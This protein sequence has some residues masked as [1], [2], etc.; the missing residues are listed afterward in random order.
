M[1]RPMTSFSVVLILLFQGG[2]LAAGPEASQKLSSIRV[3]FIVNQGQTDKRVKFY[4]K[5]F[6]GATYVT[7]SGEIV[8]DLPKVQ[9]ARKAA[10]WSLTEH[11]IGASVKSVE[12]RERAVT[13]VSS[14]VGQDSARW[15]SNIP[16]YSLVTMGEVYK[17]IRLN[18]KANGTGV[19]KL[20]YVMSGA[21]PE[22]IKMSIAGATF[23]RTN[24]KG[25]LQ[26]GTGLG[27]V[28]FTKPRAYQTTDRGTEEIEVVYAI[29]GK[30]YGFKVGQYDESK[31]LVIDPVIQVTYL[32]GTGSDNAGAIAVS[33]QNVY[34]AGSTNSTD[35]PGTAGGAQPAINALSDGYVA[36]LTADLRTLV[37]TTYFGGSGSEGSAGIAV[38]G[39]KIYVAG[40]TTSADF[41]KTAGGAQAT[42]GGGG[43]NGTDGYLALFTSDLKTLTQATYLGG[44]DD[45]SIEALAVPANSIAGYN[46]FVTGTTTSTPFPGTFG[47]AQPTGS[48]VLSP[49]GGLAYSEGFVA[50]FNSDLTALTQATYLGG[51][52]FDSAHAIAMSPGGGFVYI[53]GQTQSTLDFPNVAGGSQDTF[54][55]PPTDG[56][57][58]LLTSDLT[59]LL[60]STY[61]GGSELDVAWAVAAEE[62]AVYVAGETHSKDL[63]GTAGHAQPTLAGDFD[64]FVTKLS[65]DLRHL[66]RATYLGGAKGSFP[67]FALDRI[68]GL[69]LSPSG[70]YV[71]GL[72]GSED[73]PGTPGAQ[74]NFG[75]LSDGFVAVLTRDLQ[76]AT[77]L[78]SEDG[79]AIAI[80]GASYLGGTGAEFA[81]ALA[82]KPTEVYVAGLTASTDFPGTSGGA[83]PLNAGGSN[84]AFVAKLVLVT[85]YSLSQ[86]PPITAQPGGSGVVTATVNS[87]YGF[88]FSQ[89]KLFV[90]GQPDTIAQLPSGF[91]ATFGFPGSQ[92][93]PPINGS[94]SAPVTIDV[95]SFV[96]PGTYT[97]WLVGLPGTS[98]V[99]SERIV[100]RVSLTFA[101]LSTVLGV[102]HG[103]GCIDSSGIMDALSGKVAEA[104]ADSAAGLNQ[105][106]IDVM[107]AFSNQV[108]AQ[109]GK[110]ISMSCTLGNVS[111]DTA[112]VLI[113]DASALINNLADGLN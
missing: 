60:Q 74:E 20:F 18:L 44:R 59:T 96:V 87:L 92:L 55:G 28:A 90:S 73:F 89:V 29:K 82:V 77:F 42:F 101:G 104:Q 15:K 84:D 43:D 86:M 6:G 71:T 107:N 112:G 66:D 41:P 22:T 11:L 48:G 61:V 110:H 53:A 16:T 62:D 46:V 56:F 88:R 54:G 47:G 57:V 7:E 109:R 19:E 50:V 70:L 99:H 91:S 23:L 103:A 24:D 33:G 111:F 79:T 95:A 102:F 63:V 94:I 72:T 34:V 113:S 36:I 51:S 65:T 64:G 37:Q 78:I 85:D 69:A 67:E 35:F 13:E 8:Y 5:T 93:T 9:G 108:Q 31:E 68:V 45:D 105:D 80:A 14:F 12:G 1:K 52:S 32:G 27:T 97:L 26:V 17:G 2:I 3:P 58:S 25:E 21:K 49:R 10:G 100:L 39:T 75:G 98:I 40:T 83:Q 30:S 106:A 38:L 4:T 76:F 81:A